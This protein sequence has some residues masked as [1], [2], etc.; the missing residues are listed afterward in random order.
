MLGT[1]DDE[2]T[3]QHVS[4]DCP[5]FH[6]LAPHGLINSR[7]CCCSTAA[8]F[9]PKQALVLSPEQQQQQQQ[10]RQQQQQQQQPVS[11]PPVSVGRGSRQPAAEKMFG[12]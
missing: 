12:S 1:A 11:C 5:T 6:K 2:E 10:Q 7:C 9:N 4:T 8:S 3:N